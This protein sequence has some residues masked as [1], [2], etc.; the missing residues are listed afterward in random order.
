[1]TPKAQATK[2]KKFLPWC[3][4]LRIQLQLLRSLQ[5]CRFNPQPGAVPQG[6]GVAAVVA[7]VTAEAR[8]QSLAWE[9]PYAVSAAI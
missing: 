2:E 1:M 3:S 5:R 4:E 9:F 8:I 7:W 6:S